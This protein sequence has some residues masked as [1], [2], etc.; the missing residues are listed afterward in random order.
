MPLLELDEIPSQIDLQKEVLSEINEIYDALREISRQPITLPDE[1]GFKVSNMVRDHFRATL[2]RIL[3]LL[4]TMTVLHRESRELPVF[5]IGRAVLETIATLDHY[6]EK[7]EVLLDQAEEEEVAQKVH[8]ITI[9]YTFG[10]KK[11]SLKERIEADVAMVNALTTQEKLDKRLPGT[12]EHYE[13]LCEFAHPNSWGTRMWYA[14]SDIDSQTFSYSN[15]PP[16]G[17]ETRSLGHI[18]HMAGLLYI[19]LERHEKLEKLLPDLSRIGA[20]QKPAPGPI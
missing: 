17:M 13:D 7:I 9:K 14:K 6:C 3:D 4:E 12:Y 20:E 19:V 18:I 8:D 5:L 10:A 2:N 16:E 11:V 15:E 1:N